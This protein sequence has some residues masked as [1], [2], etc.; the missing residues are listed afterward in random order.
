ML[1]LFPVCVYER[2]SVGFVFKHYWVSQIAVLINSFCSASCC[3]DIF[4]RQTPTHFHTYTH[5]Y[6]FTYNR[7]LDCCG[8]LMDPSFLKFT[9]RELGIVVCNCVR[10]SSS[11]SLSYTPLWSMITTT[12]TTTTTTIVPY[13]LKSFVRINPPQPPLQ[14]W[15]VKFR[16]KVDC[17]KWCNTWLYVTWL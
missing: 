8:L 11:P 16:K 4:C 1:I 12:K 14:Q 9:C 13:S 2:A 17:E 7:L 3:H 6:I 15:I 10:S 5:T